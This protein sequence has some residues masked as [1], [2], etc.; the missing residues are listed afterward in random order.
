VMDRP[1]VGLPGLARYEGRAD[2]IGMLCRSSYTIMELT[3]QILEKM[4]TDLR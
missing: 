2:S 4:F 3:L 1:R